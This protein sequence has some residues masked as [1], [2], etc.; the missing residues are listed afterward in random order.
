MVTHRDSLA[1]RTQL[2]HAHS[3]KAEAETETFTTTAHCTRSV[4]K[5]KTEDRDLTAKVL[6]RTGAHPDWTETHKGPI[7]LTIKT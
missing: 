2:W 5:A 1:G 3:Q 7:I 6:G 4:W